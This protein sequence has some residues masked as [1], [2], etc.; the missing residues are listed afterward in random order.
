MA[1]I[2][3]TWVNTT[4]PAINAGNLNKL[5]NGVQ[6]AHVGFE[7]AQ[8]TANAAQ[9]AATSAQ[10]AASAAA[11][12]A[13]SA[14]A[15][16]NAASALATTVN[17]EVITARGAFLSLNARQVAQ[18]AATAAAQ[19]DADDA[20]ARAGLLEGRATN[21]ELRADSIEEWKKIVGTQQ[22]MPYFDGTFH[23][24]LAT[25]IDTGATP[26]NLRIK[27]RF[28]QGGLGTLRYL[29]DGIV[30]DGVNRFTLSRNN[31]L[32]NPTLS[33]PQ[34]GKVTTKV[35]G[36]EV[37]SGGA[38]ASVPL[39]TN[40]NKV[41]EIDLQYTEIRLKLEAIAASYLL[42]SGTRWVGYLPD[43]EI[44]VNDVTVYDF[45]LD[46]KNLVSTPTVLANN[47]IIWN[48]IAEA[49]YQ[50][51]SIASNLDIIPPR[52]N[53][54]V[55]IPKKV[56]I[57]ALSA[58]QYYIFQLCLDGKWIRYELRYD[59]DIA[60]ANKQI[61]RIWQIQLGE[62]PAE[63]PFDTS[64]FINNIVVGQTGSTFEYV[65]KPAGASDFASNSH[66]DH[67]L[68]AGGVGLYLDGRP[69]TMAVGD[70]LSGDRFEFV[71][72]SELFAPT[73]STG[74]TVGS[75]IADVD[76]RHIWNLDGFT[77]DARFVF[78]QGFNC[79]A[80]FGGMFAANREATDSVVSRGRYHGRNQVLDLANGVA[81][82]TDAGGDFF[83]Y[84][85]WNLNNKFSVSVEVNEDFMPDFAT[86]S[87]TFIDHETVYNKGY[88]GRIHT[89]QKAI[90]N[91]ERWRLIALYKLQSGV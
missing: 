15:T 74:L 1:Y 14:V 58:T 4:N 13:A 22:I 39:G 73:G 91:G 53:G 76:A 69:V 57:V 55:F 20:Q 46:Q 19:A 64:S 11:A 78:T 65:V 50:E 33:V 29:I 63:S 45:L 10:S 84:E 47:S 83:G 37:S 72:N 51:K 40:V 35:N 5:E 43:L 6:A 90:A 2:P 17:N 88:V 89:T 81:N 32:T 86:T 9:S 66:G 28:T 79:V 24:R 18:D 49:D 41:H 67:K 80:A 68:I 30:N 85:M 34:T 52:I 75:K 71:Q 87:Q 21:L 36:V 31:S 62:I 54:Y 59:N 82:F 16:A 27:G 60:G 25:P 7:A 77:M 23:G 61:W 8:T 48:G 38:T 26:V 3:T 12:N 42:A 70:I 44:T 56:Y